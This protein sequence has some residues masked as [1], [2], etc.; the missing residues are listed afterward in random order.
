MAHTDLSGGAKVANGTYRFIGRI[1]I[2]T[3][4]YKITNKT[5]NSLLRTL[6]SELLTT[7]NKLPTI[8][9]EFPCTYCKARINTM[10]SVTSQNEQKSWFEWPPGFVYRRIPSLSRN[11]YIPNDDAYCF[12][13]FFRIAQ[14]DRQADA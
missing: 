3:V 9:S 10:N 4:S 13:K 2:T 6:Y 5:Q 1:I 7:D 12:R 8:F 11:W 14:T